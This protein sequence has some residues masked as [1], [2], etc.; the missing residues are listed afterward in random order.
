MVAAHAALT[1]KT[2][3]IPD[4]YT[5]EGFDFSGTRAFDAKTGYRSK[6]FLTVPM[7]NHDHEII[8]VLQLI[9]AHD[10]ASGEVVAF[11]PSDQRLAESLASQA[12]VALTNRMLIMQLEQLFE[13]FINLMNS[14]IDEKSPYTG[15]HCQRVPV[16]TMLLAEAVNDTREGPLRD[17]TMSEKDRYELKIAGLLHDCGKVT[18]PVHIV[19]KATK[20]E[21]IFDRVAPHRHALRG[22]QARRRN[23]AAAIKDRSFRADANGG[24]REEKRLRDRLRAA[25]R[26]PQ[27]PARMQHRQRAHDATRTSRA[28]AHRALPLARHRGPRGRTSSPPTR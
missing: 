20:L 25:R 12:A 15:G 7:R 1:G 26:R 24:G 18:T 13:S 27:V 11:S 16:L 4:A 22:A 9:N 17:F 28:S 2:V 19:D 3:N 14:A 8:G 5:A 23:R 21:T 10:P 6:S